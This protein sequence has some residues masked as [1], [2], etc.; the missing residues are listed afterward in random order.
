MEFHDLDRGGAVFFCFFRSLITMRSTGKQQLISRAISKPDQTSCTGVARFTLTIN[1]CTA[2]RLRTSARW[3]TE[4][5]LDTFSAGRQYPARADSLQ[6]AKIRPYLQYAHACRDNYV[7]RYTYIALHAR[8][9]N[10]VEEMDPS[11]SA[12]IHVALLSGI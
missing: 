2:S 8:L 9:W 10:N 12:H 5:T 6:A 1:R 7:S 11:R 3:A 4:R